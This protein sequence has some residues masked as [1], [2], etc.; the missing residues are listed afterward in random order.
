MQKIS[1]GQKKRDDMTP[2]ERLRRSEM[3]KRGWATRRSRKAGG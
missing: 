2:E 1:Q 3:T